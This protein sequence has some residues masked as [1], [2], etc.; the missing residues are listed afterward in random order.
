MVIAITK[1]DKPEANVERVKQQLAEQKML[2][3]EW[4]GDTIV[5]CVSSKSKEGIDKL[6]D[7]ILLVADIEDFKAEEGV[8]GEGRL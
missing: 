3:E 8:P 6:L 4:G 1:I 5:V 2:P 7:M